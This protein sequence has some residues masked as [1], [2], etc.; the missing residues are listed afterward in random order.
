MDEEKGVSD[1]VGRIETASIRRSVDG[2]S[3]DGFS[4]D[5]FS[6]DGFSVDGENLQE[7]NLIFKNVKFNS[8]TPLPKLACICVRLWLRSMA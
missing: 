2:F 8:L 3:V 4:V 7:V 1:N 6:V 5:G